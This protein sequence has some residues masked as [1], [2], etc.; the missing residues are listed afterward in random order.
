MKHIRNGFTLVEVMLFLAVS[1]LLLAGVL[2]MTQSSISSQ[3]FNDATQSFAE[4]L[5]KVYSDV[6][7]PQ[8]IGD[9]RSDYAIYGKA[10][11]FNNNND[12]RVQK[13]SVY[14]I[15]GNDLVSNIGNVKS[16]L[17]NVGAKIKTNGP[18]DKQVNGLEEEYIPKWGSVIDGIANNDIPFTG[19][20]LVVRRSGTGLIDTLV[21]NESLKGDDGLSS[22]DELDKFSERVVDFCVNMEGYGKEANLRWD[23]RIVENARNTSGIEIID[24]DSE[25][26]KCQHP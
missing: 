23:V 9:G 19:T 13:I 25:D 20:I 11:V 1:G 21:S 7:N 10:I 4:F 26:N 22:S 5:R 2:G 15:I 3:R 8:S 12:T 18:A 14:D 16:M 6:S 24:L 17:I